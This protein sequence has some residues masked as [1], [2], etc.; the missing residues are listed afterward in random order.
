[1]VAFIDNVK[2]ILEEP[3]PDA[4]RDVICREIGS[5]L[6]NQ[7]YKESGTGT[8]NGTPPRAI[9]GRSDDEQIAWPK[10]T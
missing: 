4:D 9:A 10:L 6:I 7:S 3:V 5:E 2:G 8:F 1:M